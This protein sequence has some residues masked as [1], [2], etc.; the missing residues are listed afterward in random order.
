MDGTLVDAYGRKIDY[1]RVSVTE[2][3]DFHCLYCGGES[4]VR[5]LPLDDLARLVAVSLSCGIRHVRITGG[6]PLLRDG[7]VPFIRRIRGMDGIETITM[8][9]NGSHLGTYAKELGTIPLSGVNVSLDATDP[10][11][12]ARLSGGG[13]VDAVVDGIDLLLEAGIPVKLNCVP[14]SPYWKEQTEQTYRFAASRHVPLRFIELMPFG[15]ASSLG[16]VPVERIASFLSET[17]G[18]S[19]I[20]RMALGDGPADYRCYHGIS[21]G[22]IGALTHRFCGRCNRI[23]LLCD[24]KLKLCLDQDPAVDLAPLLSGSDEM[25]QKTLRTAVLRKQ[26]H[27]HFGDGSK[28]REPLGC[29]GG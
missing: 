25:L 16:G 2:A 29:I 10:A 19:E 1:L 23:R 8:T 27:H 24:G 9:T 4:A 15:P 18:E 14:L 21:V 7:V 22:F 26:E 13:N 11:L 3:C 20:S 5:P 6:E 17:Y 12:F 28:M